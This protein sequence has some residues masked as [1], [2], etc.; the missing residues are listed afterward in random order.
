MES[1]FP[2]IQVYLSCRDEHMYLLKDQEKTICKTDLKD[3]KNKFAYIREIYCDLTKHPVESFMNES[4]IPIKTNCLPKVEKP[5]SSVLITRCV[6]PVKNLTHKQIKE[7][8]EI[9]KNRH[10]VPAINKPIDQYDLVV[11]VES[12]EI[13]EAAALGK[14]II[15]IPTGF[16]ENLFKS[17]FPWI[18]IMKLD[19]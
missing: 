16:G 18:E 11:G 19:Y 15:L 12:E 1:T 7:I 10:L 14:Q 6:P 8:L 9:L 17:M 3:A 2:G 13:Y 4:D 5:S